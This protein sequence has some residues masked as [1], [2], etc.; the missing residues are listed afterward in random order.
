MHEHEEILRERETGTLTFKY[1][2]KARSL[3]VLAPHF[4][5]AFV[6]LAFQ[7]TNTY[8]NVHS[9]THMHTLTSNPYSG[10]PESTA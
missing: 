2:S 5:I 6:C 8:T 4:L 1:G 7:N 10:A 3:R 9:H